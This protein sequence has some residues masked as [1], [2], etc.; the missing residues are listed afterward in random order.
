MTFRENS[1]PFKTVASS[2]SNAQSA[3]LP[4]VDF[5]GDLCEFSNQHSY[6]RDSDISSK[7][8][9]ESTSIPHMSIFP[10]LRDTGINAPISDSS[11]LF[12]DSPIVVTD[13][14]VPVENLE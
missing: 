5:G 6:Q 4:L 11:Q 8:I 10:N 9:R 12:H 2:E 13:I 3:A 14:T 7:Y 1:F